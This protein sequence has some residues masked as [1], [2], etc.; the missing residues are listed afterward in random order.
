[1]VT[2]D[3]I[4]TYT[5]T[6]ESPTPT[7]VNEDGSALFNYILTPRDPLPGELPV[8]EALESIVY[9]PQTF[10]LVAV[11]EPG[12]LLLSGMGLLA[13]LRRRR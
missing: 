12:S 8:G 1:M 9:G 4:N 10:S 13:L 7:F 5:F 2:F 3:G 11:P 6:I